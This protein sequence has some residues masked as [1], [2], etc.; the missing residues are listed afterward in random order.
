MAWPSLAASISISA[1]S[2]RF[3]QFGP[4]LHIHD[5]VL[6]NTHTPGWPWLG[7]PWLPSSPSPQIPIASVQQLPLLPPSTVCVFDSVCVCVCMY[8]YVCVRVCVCMYVYVC[9][10]VCVCMCMC[11]CVYVCV[12]VCACMCAC[13]RVRMCACVICQLKLCVCCA[14]DGSKPMILEKC[15]SLSALTCVCSQRRS[16][17]KSVV[18]D[19]H[20]C[21]VVREGHT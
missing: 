18:R 9:V 2:N 13:V 8:M 16:C 20:A 10:Y 6:T 1:G 21:S 3:F 12:C 17:V 15:H 14:L 4:T 5:Y 19:G 7:H 11:A